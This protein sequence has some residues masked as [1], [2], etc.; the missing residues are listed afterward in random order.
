M[1]REVVKVNAQNRQEAICALE[2]L[3][4]KIKNNYVSG[5]IEERVLVTNEG[6]V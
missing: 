1:E 5:S 4:D 6:V 2:M 3:L